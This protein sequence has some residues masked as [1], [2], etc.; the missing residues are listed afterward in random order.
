MDKWNETFEK[1]D[2]SM[3]PVIKTYIADVSSG[4]YIRSLA[5]RIGKDLG[6][7]AITL[8]ISRIYIEI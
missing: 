7:N 2:L 1:I 6:T 8:D 3:K 4:T 5:D